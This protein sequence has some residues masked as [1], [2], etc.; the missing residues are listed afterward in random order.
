MCLNVF[1]L[2]NQVWKPCKLYNA[3]TYF[4][5]NAYLIRFLSRLAEVSSLIRVVEINSL[6]HLADAHKLMLPQ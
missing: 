2:E 3:A 1:D 5:S 6:N 4:T